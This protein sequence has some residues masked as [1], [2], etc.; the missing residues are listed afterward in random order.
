MAGPPDSSCS[1]YRTGYVFI[2]QLPLLRPAAFKPNSSA[3]CKP[4]RTWQLPKVA[5]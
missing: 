1:A 2:D 3:S 4:E 5:K